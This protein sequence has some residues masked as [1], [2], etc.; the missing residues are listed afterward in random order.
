MR[1]LSLSMMNLLTI[2]A[3]LD[4]LDFKAL[5]WN[6]FKTISPVMMELKNNNN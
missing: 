1:V 4:Y 2:P 6:L 3:L 5:L